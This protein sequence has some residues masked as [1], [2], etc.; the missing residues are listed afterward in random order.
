M[1]TFTQLYYH[2]VFSSKNRTNVFVAN[3]RPELYA[4]MGGIIKNKKSTPHVINGVEN[5]IH[6]LTNIHP[7]I[8]LS[9]F[10]KDIKIASSLWI[11]ENNMFPQFDG[12]QDGYGAFTLSDQEKADV[13]GYII[14]QEEHH[15]KRTFREELIDLLR[16]AGIS[17]DEKYLL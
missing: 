12:W 6:I 9:D 11:R 8:A 16:K 3:K 10:V 2:I 14:N 1:A 17:F 4:Y 15:R 7:R 13:S 5:H